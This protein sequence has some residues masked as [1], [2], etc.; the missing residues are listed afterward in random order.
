MLRREL[1]RL[2]GHENGERTMNAIHAKLET[3]TTDILWDICRKLATDCTSEA[4]MISEAALSIL[5][6]RV[7]SVQFVAFCDELYNAMA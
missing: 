1:M 4:N 6:I 2:A 3:M 5:E 7:S